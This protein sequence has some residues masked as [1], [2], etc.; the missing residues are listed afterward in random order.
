MCCDQ[1]RSG[2][3]EGLLL[4]AVMPDGAEDDGS[5][6]VEPAEMPWRLI[7]ELHVITVP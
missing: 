4:V 5:R 3:T 2:L 6:T 1:L 7:P